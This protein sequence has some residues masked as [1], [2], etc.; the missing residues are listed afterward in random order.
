ME[1]NYLIVAPVFVAILALV[2]FLIRKNR[3]DQ[4]EFEN[5]IIQTELKPDKHDDPIT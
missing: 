4:K 3:K 2:F 5:E 1:I